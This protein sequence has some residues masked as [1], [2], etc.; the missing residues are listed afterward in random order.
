M[1]LGL[2]DRERPNHGQGALFVFEVLVVGSLALGNPYWTWVT[3]VG[4]PTW[5]TQVQRG[6]SHVGYPPGFF[7][8][9]PGFGQI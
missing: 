1:A 8:F 7:H 3:H 6:F 9:S 4:F 5:V 2:F